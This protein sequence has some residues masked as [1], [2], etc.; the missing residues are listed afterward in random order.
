MGNSFVEAFA[1]GIPVIATQEGGIA[2]FL[3]DA[4]RNP[5]RETTGWAVDKDSPEDIAKAVKNIL[6]HPDAV[7][8]VTATAKALAF[9]DYDWDTIARAMREEVFSIL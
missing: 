9:S 2:D 7:A 5:D 1:A 3:F 6:A 4:K 8:R